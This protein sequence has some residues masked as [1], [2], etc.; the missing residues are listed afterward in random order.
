VIRLIR[1]AAFLLIVV[2]AGSAYAAEKARYD[3]PKINIRIPA[4]GDPQSP[5]PR[6]LSLAVSVFMD[7]RALELA[8]RRQG[9]LRGKYFQATA[10]AYFRIRA[11]LMQPLDLTLLQ[12]LLT[13]ELSDELNGAPVTLLFREFVVK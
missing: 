7:E 3:F 9:E 8:Q 6:Q 4:P 5:P 2:A 10:S 11:G 13:S 12:E 1:Y